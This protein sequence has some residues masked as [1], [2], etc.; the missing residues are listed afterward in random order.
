MIVETGQ[1]EFADE[2]LRQAARAA[3]DAAAY[4]ADLIAKAA[5]LHHRDQC[6]REFHGI[7]RDANHSDQ[8]PGGGA[9]YGDMGLALPI[10]APGGVASALT[11]CSSADPAGDLPQGVRRGQRSAGLRAIAEPHALFDPT[12]EDDGGADSPAAIGSTASSLSFPRRP[13]PNCSLSQHTNGRPALF[14]VEAA[15]AGR[16]R[17]RRSQHGAP[18]CGTRPGRAQQGVVSALGPAG[19]GRRHRCRNRVVLLRKLSHC[20]GLGWAAL[21]VGTSHA[22]LDYVIPYVKNA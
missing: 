3:D 16:H 20:P 5:E 22:V 11:H 1:I 7:C 18:R 6:S 14:I 12:A 13:M 9:A 4:P 2:V 10:L 8:R 21:A 17:H 19:R 15:T